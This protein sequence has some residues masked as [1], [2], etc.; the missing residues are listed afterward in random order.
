MSPQDLWHQRL[1]HLLLYKLKGISL[2]PKI[3][4]VHD[5]NCCV[6]SQA[7]QS[8]L[9][10]SPSTLS[11]SHI[12]DLVHANWWVP[13][14]HRYFLTLLGD[15][16]LCTWTDLLSSKSNAFSLIKAFFNMVET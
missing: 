1:R 8:R 12:F 9:P 2:S 10:F 5:F 14:G 6:C 13:Y 11:T 15:Y 7:R 4:K 3:D 16:S